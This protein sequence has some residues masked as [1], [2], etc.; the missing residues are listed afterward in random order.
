MRQTL[1]YYCILFQRKKLQ[2]FLIFCKNLKISFP[3]NNCYSISRQL[4]QRMDLCQE[5]S[6]SNRCSLLQQQVLRLLDEGFVID[7]EN[8][9]RLLQALNTVSFEMKEAGDANKMVRL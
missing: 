3:V 8:Q 7:I 4:Q 9:H 2:W 6:Y 5:R 1:V